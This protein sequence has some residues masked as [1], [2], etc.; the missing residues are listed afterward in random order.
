MSLI[1]IEKDHTCYLKVNELLDIFKLYV[2]FILIIVNNFFISF[3]L[4][5]QDFLVSNMNIVIKTLVYFQK[6]I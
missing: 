3:N 1:V 2:W 4:F 6:K 5:Y